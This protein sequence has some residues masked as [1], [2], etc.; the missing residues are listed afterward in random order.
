MQTNSTV[1][2]LFHGTNKLPEVI[3][4]CTVGEDIE[5]ASFLIGNI[6]T[7]RSPTI[8]RKEVVSF[9]SNLAELSRKFIDW[10]HGVFCARTEPKNFSKSFTPFSTLVPG[11]IT[12]PSSVSVIARVKNLILVPE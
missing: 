11:A 12:S 3:K 10:S 4:C 2:D 9:L 7:G 6:R 8:E 1:S 5:Q